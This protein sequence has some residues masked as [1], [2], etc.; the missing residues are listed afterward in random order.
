MSDAK[1][2]ALGKRINA[3]L[4]RVDEEREA[5]K[6]LYAEA[7]SAGNIPKMLRKAITRMRMDASKREE[8]D[9][10]LDLYDHALGN[11]GAA[12]D[13]IEGGATWEEAGKAHGVPRATL[14]RAA[15]VSKRREMI[16]EENSETHRGAMPSKDGAEVMRAEPSM[17]GSAVASGDA[18]RDAS[19]MPL[20]VAAAPYSEGRE[21]VGSATAA[22]SASDPDDGLEIP[23][24][25][26]RSAA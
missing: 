17:S 16:L 11:V 6:D 21:H 25:L 14:A 22:P 7:K 8:E 23:Q 13:A 20:D 10:I 5:V 19:A 2:V 3:A 15:A 24:F 26:R 18:V 9:S 4:D 12:L 1:L